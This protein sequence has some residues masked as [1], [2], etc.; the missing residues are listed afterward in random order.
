MN[1]YFWC[2]L[3]VSIVFNYS[4]AED[5]YKWVDGFGIT[6]YGDES[7]MKGV[8]SSDKVKIKT[9]IDV[10]KNSIDYIPVAAQIRQKDTYSNIEFNVNIISPMPNEII[11]NKEGNVEVIVGINPIPPVEYTLRIFI[12]DSLYAS[13]NN[14]TKIVISKLPKGDHELVVKLQNK[15]GKIFATVPTKF[16]LR[17]FNNK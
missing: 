14:S 4:Y 5:V 16:T 10:K 12:D 2:A 13:A 11:D 9:N 6:H 15:N 1:K 3:I 17:K 8:H 7:K